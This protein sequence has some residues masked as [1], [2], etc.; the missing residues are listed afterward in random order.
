M[1]L[2]GRRES[3]LGILDGSGVHEFKRA[4]LAGRAALETGL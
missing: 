2:W 1:T 4:G 3:G